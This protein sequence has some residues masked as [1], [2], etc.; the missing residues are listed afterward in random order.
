MPVPPE[1][2]KSIQHMTHYSNLSNIIAGGIYSG[3]ELRRQ[4]IVPTNIGHT[5]LKNDRSRRVVNIQPGGTLDNYVPFF[6]TNRPPMIVAIARGAVS[7][8]GG[9][10]REVVYLVSSTKTIVD[11]SCP[12]CFTDGHAV[13]RITDYYN[14]LEDLRNIDWPAVDAWD[15]RPTASD[16]DRQR[17]KQAEFLVRNHV[18]WECIES[19]TVK[20]LEMNQI[21][22][23]IIHSSHT[24][25]APSININRNWYYNPRRR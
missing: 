14:Q 2:N 19:I 11:Y 7:D 18:P 3:C 17:K 24:H 4:H 23:Q 10:Q 8:Y 16:P 25:H 1:Q 12:Y 20:D 15:W 5:Q 22:Q 21:V 13:E 9:T 6:F